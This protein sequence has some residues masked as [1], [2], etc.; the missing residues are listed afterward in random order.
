MAL[1]WKRTI[2][3]SPFLQTLVLLG[4][5]VDSLD[6]VRYTQLVKV[7]PVVTIYMVQRLLKS[8]C[9]LS[10]LDLFLMIENILVSSAKSLILHCMMSG[11]YGETKL[12]Q[13]YNKTEF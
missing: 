5:I 1:D 8:D 11:I 12:T 3:P 13:L 10:W 9:S 7:C 6:L 2:H 4:D